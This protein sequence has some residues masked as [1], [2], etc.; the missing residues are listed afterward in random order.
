MS[1]SG[2]RRICPLIDGIRYRPPA[3]CN[4]LRTSSDGGGAA[5]AAA[6]TRSAENAMKS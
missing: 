2:P 5:A 6:T 4:A 3:P 1:R